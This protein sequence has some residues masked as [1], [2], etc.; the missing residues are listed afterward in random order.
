MRI[1]KFS[2]E[3]IQRIF[4]CSSVIVM[5]TAFFASKFRKRKRSENSEND[6]N[7][8]SLAK[9]SMKNKPKNQLPK[10]KSV[11]TKL[12][13]FLS[14]NDN[15]FGKTELEENSETST[16]FV[17]KKQ[18]NFKKK[19]FMSDCESKNEES[20]IRGNKFETE[21][22]KMNEFYFAVFEKLKH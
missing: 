5:I 8:L 10:E 4:I 16:H 17:N 6:S 2:N 20:K 9:N 22:S 12:A 15:F 14:D 13:T 1:P 11:K 19:V 3:D 7:S 18:V 21:D